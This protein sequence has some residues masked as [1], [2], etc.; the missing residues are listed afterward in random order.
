MKKLLAIFLLFL[1]AICA[2][3]ASAEPASDR[4]VVMISVDGLAHYYFDDPKA[5]MPNIRALAT[6]GARANMMKAVMPTV[7][8]P[9]HTTLVT[10]DLPARH[11]VL[12][13]DYFDRATNEMVQLITDP[14]YDE[15]QIVKVPTIYDLAHDK[16]LKTAAITWP[17]SRSAPSLDWTAPDMDKDA[18]Y[19]KYSTPS[20]L[21]EARDAGIH[22]EKLEEWIKAN[23]GDERDELY[24]Q[25]F[26]LVL[27]QHRPNLALLHLINIDHEEHLHGPQTTESYVAVAA[28]D[29]R[30]G[31]VWQKL[32]KDFPGK[33]T[34]VVVSDHGFL[35]YRQYIMP[36]VALRKAGLMDVKGLKIIGAKVRAISQGGSSFVYILDS[37]HHDELVSQTAA[38]FNAMEGIGEVVPAKQFAKIGMGDSTTDPRLPDLLLSAKSGY[39]FGNNAAGEIAVTTPLKDLHGTHGNDANLPEL[40]ATFVAWGAGIRA[41]AK[42]GDIDNVDVAPTLAKLLGFEMKDVDGKAIEGALAPIQ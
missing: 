1:R 6:E 19:Q 33:A 4:I 38:I 14:V 27:E 22:Y 37:A 35:P 16:G 25:L 28:A 30:V 39:T 13:N 5:D 17:A 18:S 24:L 29:R 40:H 8:W 10:G 9:N 32:K 34:L 20:L 41:G 23:D 26:I 2:A 12:G 42:L 11:G 31:K 36:N 3:R 21:Q 7:T 15:R